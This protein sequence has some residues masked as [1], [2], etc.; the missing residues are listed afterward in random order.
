[1][2]VR[3]IWDISPELSFNNFEMIL[4]LIKNDKPFVSTKQRDG[5]NIINGRCLHYYTQKCD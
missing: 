2:V 4:K 1:M 3:V 5:Y